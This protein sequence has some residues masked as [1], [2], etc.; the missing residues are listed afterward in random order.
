M[1]VVNI[2]VIGPNGSPASGSLTWTPVAITGNPSL[3][4]PQTVALDGTGTESVTLTANDSTWVWRVDELVTGVD[5]KS[6]Y[7]H[8]PTTGTVSYKALVRA[9]PVTGKASASVGRSDVAPTPTSFAP[10]APVAPP[11]GVTGSGVYTRQSNVYGFPANGLRRTR[12]A[13][14]RA[15]AG[16]GYAKIVCIGDSI[17]VGVGATNKYVG[18]WPMVLRSVLSNRGASIGGTGWCFPWCNEGLTNDS[19]WTYAGGFNV[20]QFDDASTMNFVT[21]RATGATLQ[22]TSDQPGTVVDIAFFNN[23]GAFTYSID[24]AAAV[25]V[26]PP[27]G[28]TIGKLTVTGLANTTH[29]VLI[30]TTTAS[31]THI[32]AI[33]VRN[34]SSGLLVSNPAVGSSKTTPW[35][36]NGLGASAWY[37]SGKLTRADESAPDLVII[38]P[39]IVNDAQ[40]AG[41]Q[42]PPATSQSNLVDMIGAFRGLSS[43]PDILMVMPP[44]PNPANIP[45]ATWTPYVQAVYAAADSTGVPLIDVA[46]RWGSWSTANGLGLMND[47]YHPSNAGYQDVGRA[48]ASLLMPA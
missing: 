7:V 21:A 31:F 36:T 34:A 41:G 48:I 11:S 22:F 17:T 40:T 39:M 33:Q 15:A 47:I 6:F 32:S 8:V 20:Y 19:R 24:G 4:A 30:T 45:T 25:T 27:G 44:T 38:E 3:P 35:T 37:D 26:N 2:T 13:L 1:T 16:S 23:S 12:A 28:Q 46:D 14:A 5:F 18:S 43:T 9:D 42:V 29:T 10:L